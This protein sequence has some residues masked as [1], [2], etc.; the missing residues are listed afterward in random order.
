MFSCSFLFSQ[1]PESLR[2]PV[3]EA[4]DKI[5]QISSQI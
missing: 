5:F 3:K 4:E 2:L 1:G